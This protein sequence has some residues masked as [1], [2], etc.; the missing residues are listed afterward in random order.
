[1]GNVSYC[2]VGSIVSSHRLCAADCLPSGVSM[3]PLEP[4]AQ[5]VNEPKGFEQQQR[6]DNNQQQLDTHMS[7]ERRRRERKFPILKLLAGLV[8]H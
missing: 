6:H 8:P 5:S 1:M 2:T 4:P 3:E 7:Y